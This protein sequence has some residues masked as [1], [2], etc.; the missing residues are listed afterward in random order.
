MINVGF[1]IFLLA[2]IA[3]WMLKD[4]ENPLFRAAVRPVAE[5]GV[6][7]QAKSYNPEA[8]KVNCTLDLNYD[9]GCVN[10][11]PHPV[12]IWGGQTVPHTR[13]A[14]AEQCKASCEKF[15]AGNCVWRENGPDTNGG[16]SCYFVS[17]PICG[18]DGMSSSP[19]A[20]LSP[21]LVKAIR[22]GKCE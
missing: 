1:F 16:T 10:P 22:S 11:T 12:Y 9:F 2:V 5:D 17:N 15:G 13:V 4:W 20:S 18:P 19:F 14:T 21:S 3:G 6:L 7:E 8:R